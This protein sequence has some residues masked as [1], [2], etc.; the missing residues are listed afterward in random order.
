MDE[1]NLTFQRRRS[2]RNSA[3]R[4]MDGCDDG[5]I[6]ILC[7]ATRSLTLPPGLRNCTYALVSRT[8]SRSQAILTSALPSI[9]IPSASLKELILTKGVFPAIK[10]IAG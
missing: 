2:L 9:S 3:L 10:L 7:N 1:D 5:E 6:H 8:T 4:W